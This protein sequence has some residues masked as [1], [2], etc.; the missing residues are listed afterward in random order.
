[1][2]LRKR[3]LKHDMLWLKWPLTLL[4]VV[5]I[6]SAGLYISASMFRNEMQR[7]EF[8]AL[9]DYDLITGQVDE[10][11][12]AERVITNNIDRYNVMVVNGVMGEED[13]VALLEDIT[14]I[15]QRHLLFPMNVEIGEE[16]RLFIP[17]PEEV[18]FPDDQITLRESQVRVSYALLHEED[19]TRFLTEFLDSG[20]L[21]V[22]VRCS[23]A[24]ALASDEQAMEVVQ[25]QLANCEFNWYTFRQEPYLG[26]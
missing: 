8:N 3:T 12:Q 26:F 18:D 23:V 13:R 14:A 11:A 7:E 22:P 4:G 1:M 17:Y 20:R 15:R 19:L 5:V 16:E 10:I 2:A 25:H 24:A 6:A 21:M 9:S